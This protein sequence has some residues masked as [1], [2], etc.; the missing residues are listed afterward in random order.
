MR[1]ELPGQRVLL[2]LA[3]RPSQVVVLRGLMS[4][5]GCVEKACR[6]PLTCVAELQGL[7]SSETM[8][9]ESPA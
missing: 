9:V 4:L 3:S 6:T 5:T 7:L 1:V 2:G 8:A